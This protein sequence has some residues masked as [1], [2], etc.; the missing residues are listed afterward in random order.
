VLIAFRQA[1][2][3]ITAAS[4][5]QP[6]LDEVFLAITGHYTDTEIAASTEELG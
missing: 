3:G 1:Q 4:V 6:T 2:V 5:R